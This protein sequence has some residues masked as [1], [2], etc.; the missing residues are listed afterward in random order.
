MTRK[1]SIFAAVFTFIGL[2]L[3]AQAWIEKTSFPGTERSGAVSFPVGNYGYVGSGGSKDFYKYDPTFDSWTKIADYP[4][5][6]TNG[7]VA[8]TIDSNAYVGLGVNNENYTQLDFWMYDPKTNA[9][10]QKANCPVDRHYA[11]GFSIGGKGYIGLGYRNGNRNEVYEYDPVGNKWSKKY[12]FPGSARNNAACFVIGNYGYVCCGWATANTNELWQYD[13]SNDSWTQK[14]NFTGTA[15]N[16]ACSFT[17]NNLGYVGTGWDGGFTNNFKR[18]NPSN[19]SWSE[20]LS[21]PYGNRSGA[22]AFVIGEYAYFGTGYDGS[23]STKKFYMLNPLPAYKETKALI[24]NLSSDQSACSYYYANNGF[25]TFYGRFY[26][27]PIAPFTLYNSCTENYN[28]SLVNFPVDLEENKTYIIV[29]NG[30][31][32]NTGYTPAKPYELHIFSNAR[33]KSTIENKVDV[34]FYNGSTDCPPVDIYNKN[35]GELLVDNLGYSLFSNGYISLPPEDI[36]LDIKDENS[37]TPGEYYFLPLLNKQGQ[38][39]MVFAKG[40]LYPENNNNGPEVSMY[41]SNIDNTGNYRFKEL[42]W[43][44]TSSHEVTH[45]NTFKVSPNPATSHIQIQYNLSVK[46]EVS[47]QLTN[48]NGRKIKTIMGNTLKFPGKNKDDITLPPYLPAGVYLIKLH[49]VN[50]EMYTKLIIQ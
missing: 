46:S 50:Q 45:T 49:F 26:S 41:C 3:N 13:P 29:N 18:Y 2:Y 30:I 19:N 31:R 14:A 6:G 35:T 11:V 39:I 16:G 27:Y 7:L 9:W 44:E 38:A 1:V 32:S 47:V 17:L 36:I 37:T 42:E 10:S 25:E 8:F 48:I 43:I 15:R 22:K 28:D 24:L 5:L 33:N 23:V 12:D 34:L 4:G 21:F 40:F 20:G